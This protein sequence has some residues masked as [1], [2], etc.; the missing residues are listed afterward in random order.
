MKSRQAEPCPNSLFSWQG[1]FP[2]TNTGEDGY[3]ST[4][5]VDAF[6]PQN[7]LGLRDVVGN[8]WEWVS[9][10]WT[11]DRSNYSEVQK[12]NPGVALVWHGAIVHT[13]GE[14]L[15]TG[16]DMGLQRSQGV[17]KELS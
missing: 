16:R 2:D 12:Y 8:A 13:F 11:P 9:D 10:W 5:P 4:S 1:R 7:A 3:R 6:P 14:R 17:S 15:D